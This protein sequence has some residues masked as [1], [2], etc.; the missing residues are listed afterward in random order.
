MA[1]PRSEEKQQALLRAATEIFAEQG[2]AASTIT[3][4]RKASVSEG[5]LFHY[6]E[7]K[8]NL[9]GAVGDYLLDEIET[10]LAQRL[11]AAAPGT[12]KIQVGW[13]AYIDW[14][15]DNPAAYAAGNKLMVSGKL[16]DAQME[17]SMR[18][19]DFTMPDL[20]IIQG[21]DAT[22]TGEFFGMLSTAIA[23]GVIDMA[24]RNP[25]LL[26]IYKKAGYDAMVRAIGLPDSV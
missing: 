8:D 20:P 24:V 13:N 23:N 19:G 25:R 18:L 3:I 11:V 22:E 21:L 4:A 2:L 17:R 5:T 12:N 15:L 6:F 14:A 16:S 9:I 10:L 26:D 1:R 7:N